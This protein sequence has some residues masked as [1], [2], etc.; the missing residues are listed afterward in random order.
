MGGAFLLQLQAGVHLDPPDP[1]GH[2]LRR[3]CSVEEALRGCPDDAMNFAFDRLAGSRARTTAL[4]LSGIALAALC[5]WPGLPGPFLLDD[6]ENLKQLGRN[7]F[8]IRSFSDWLEFV[9]GGNSGPLGRPV[10]LAS[11]TV[12][13]QSWP[14]DPWPFK[15]TNLLI[16]LCNGTLVF[17]L[18][19]RI[20]AIAGIRHADR[21]AWLCAAFWMV[22]P[23]QVSTVLYVV[24][25]MAELAS[26][27]TLAGVYA[28]VHGRVLV[29]A[30]PLRGY[31]WIV[32]GIVGGGALAV[33][34]KENGVLLPLFALTLE[35]TVL[36]HLPAPPAWR[37]AQA[38]LLRIP[39]LALIAYLALQSPHWLE[40]YQLRSFTPLERLGTQG[41][42]LLDYIYRISIPRLS[43]SGLFFDHYPIV[44][45]AVMVALCWSGVGGLIIT[46][47]AMRRRYPLAAAA[48]LWFFAGHLLESTILGLELYFEHRNYL[49]LF[50]PSLLVGLMLVSADRVRL[51]AAAGLVAIIALLTYAQTRVWGDERLAAKVWPHENP[52][53]ARAHQIA[54]IA[55]Q[56]QRQFDRPIEL[57]RSYAAQNPNDPT[58]RLQLIEVACVF[59]NPV[60]VYATNT[61]PLL[62]TGTYTYGALDALEHLIELRRRGACTGLTQKTLLRMIQALKD[63]PTVQ[64]LPSQLAYLTYVEAQA[65]IAEESLLPAISTA[66]APSSTPNA[67]TATVD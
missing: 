10:S 36:R 38:F 57:M 64:A 51:A 3:H 47:I 20:Y 31:A 11:F 13:A 58:T 14:A 7:G 52:K 23:L 39:V 44:D 37:H 59:D 49:P 66:E 22:H 19:R 62:Y 63:N 42:I 65:R 21:C 2:L 5:Y 43:G 33:L 1:Q 34:S 60:D 17:L 30:S 28:Y 67:D 18:A 50:G 12:N 53:S 55:W 46:A 27:F 61:I 56:K 41:Q 45:N 15:F 26:L 40:A 35:V 25:R 16:H 32:G 24:Q 54:V 8:G 4:L 48:I 6:H 9:F 29:T